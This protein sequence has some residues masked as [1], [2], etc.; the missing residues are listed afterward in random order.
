M[1]GPCVFFWTKLD[2]FRTN[3]IDSTH[4]VS[5][6]LDNSKRRTKRLDQSSKNRRNLQT[7][8]HELILP[9]QQ[10]QPRNEFQ[11]CART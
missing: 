2:A 10:H 5:L 1:Y 8:V 9:L 3:D 6:S 11:V 4:D 7:S